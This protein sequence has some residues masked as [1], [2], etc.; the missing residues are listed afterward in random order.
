[1][2]FEFFMKHVIRSFVSPNPH[3]DGRSTLKCSDRLFQES[4]V[5]IGLLPDLDTGQVNLPLLRV[6]TH[7]RHPCRQ[8]EGQ[9]VVNLCINITA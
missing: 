1:M 2:S 7:P 9:S 5:T 6:F 8:R 4:H 3:R